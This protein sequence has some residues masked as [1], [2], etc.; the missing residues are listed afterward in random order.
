[1]RH[2]D[3]PPKVHGPRG[4]CPPPAPLLVALRASIMKAIYKKPKTAREFEVALQH[5]DL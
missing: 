3:G 2:F 4:H 1:M 5:F